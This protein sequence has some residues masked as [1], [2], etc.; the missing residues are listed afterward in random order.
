[1]T[2]T[3]GL[4]REKR[5]RL[6]SGVPHPLQYTKP[7]APGLGSSAK[8]SGTRRGNGRPLA[9]FMV[10]PVIQWSF[11]TDDR[12]HGGQDRSRESGYRVPRPLRGD[13]RLSIS[14]VL[15]QYSCQGLTRGADRNYPVPVHE[16]ELT[17]VTLLRFTRK[18]VV[19]AAGVRAYQ[20]D[21]RG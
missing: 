2:V 15:R 18:R 19:P 9:K 1:M 13:L 4:D 5:S 11:C 10:P 6:S 16:E 12:R 21:G 14:R 7:L 17:G 8:I 20:R 3:V